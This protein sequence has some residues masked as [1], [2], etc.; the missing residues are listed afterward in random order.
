M[1]KFNAFLKKH[2]TT[3]AVVGCIWIIIL[4]IHRLTAWDETL[5]E[6]LVGLAVVLPFALPIFLLR[7]SR[8]EPQFR[9]GGNRRIPGSGIR[10]SYGAFFLASLSM[11][12]FL[13]LSA[14]AKYSQTESIAIIDIYWT[15]M[16]APE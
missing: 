13:T 12:A 11:S 3:I 7:N 1:K 10:V 9:L 8:Q 15:L 14:F 4:V 2:N 6:S 16:V 5:I